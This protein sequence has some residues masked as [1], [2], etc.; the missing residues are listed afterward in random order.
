MSDHNHD[1]N[2]NVLSTGQLLKM[3]LQ[4]KVGTTK[5]QPAVHDHKAA[6]AAPA[7]GQVNTIAIVLDGEVQEVIRAE[8]RLTALM[9]SDPEFIL[10]KTGTPKPTIGWKYIDGEFKDPYEEV[11]VPNN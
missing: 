10:V 8:H 4:K 9:L 11:E 5:K 2:H 7:H 1:H 6:P 3:W